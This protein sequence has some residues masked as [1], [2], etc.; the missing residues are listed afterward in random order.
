MSCSH[1]NPS[2]HVP[3]GWVA[4]APP[5][6]E[7]PSAMC[8]NAA[9]DDWAVALAADSN[10]LITRPAAGENLADTLRLPNGQFVSETRG[11]FGGDVRWITATGTSEHV[12]S[13]NIVAFFHTRDT[14]WGLTGLAHLSLNTGQ[15]VRFDRVGADWQITP[16]AELGAAPTAFLRLSR[17]SL[18]VLGVGRVIRLSPTHAVEVLHANPVWLDTYPRSVVRNKNGVVYLGMRSGVARLTPSAVGYRED[19]LVPV[20]C[21]HRVPTGPGRECRCEA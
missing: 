15:L 10:T 4:I 1:A 21:R 5:A 18:L 6:V 2:E 16:V 17:D 12:A 11:E 13:T 20:A 7:S 14:L 8:A 19:W 9:R 3:A